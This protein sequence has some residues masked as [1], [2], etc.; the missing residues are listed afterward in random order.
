MPAVFVEVEDK[1]LLP[2]KSILSP[3]VGR[4]SSIEKQYTVYVVVGFQRVD[5]DLSCDLQ[6]PIYHKVV[7]NELFE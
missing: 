5:T 3:S 1:R 6:C 2:L 7:C 4:D